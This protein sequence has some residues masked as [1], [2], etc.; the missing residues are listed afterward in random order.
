MSESKETLRQEALRHRTLM[1][2]RSEDPDEACDVFFQ[3][4]NPAKSQVV[5]VYWPKDKEFNPHAIIER[6]Q[7]QGNELALPV[8]QKDSRIL[9]FATWRDGDRL[10]QGAYGVMEPADKSWVDPDILIVPLLAFDRRGYRLGYGRGYYDTTLKDLRQRKQ[11][12]AV[13]VGFGQQACLFNL[14]A[15]DHDERLD[16]VITP[17]QAYNFME[18]R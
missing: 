17:K 8:V 16:W 4:I 18:K 6:L 11:I 2:P 7:K 13:G 12:L 14:P 10:E 1:D 5:A 15:E 3:H 9:K